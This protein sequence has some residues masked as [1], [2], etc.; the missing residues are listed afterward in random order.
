MNWTYFSVVIFYFGYS[1]TLTAQDWDIYYMDQLRVIATTGLSVRQH[2]RA[3]AKRL[4]VV[5]FGKTVRALS[6]KGYGV[7]TVGYQTFTE[8]GEERPRDCQVPI[9]GQW[10]RVRYGKLQGYV[11][12]AYLVE[13]LNWRERVQDLNQEVV[14]MVPGGDCSVEVRYAPNWYW[15][16]LYQTP[17][18]YA[19]Q[20]VRPTFTNNWQTNTLTIS[21]QNNK[22][23][24]YIIGSRR[25]LALPSAI[26][27]KAKAGEG[28]FWKASLQQNTIPVYAHQLSVKPCSTPCPQGPLLHV[29]DE[30]TDQSLQVLNPPALRLQEPNQLHWCGDLDGDGKDDYI[31]EYASETGAEVLY[32]S[33]FAE[34][35]QHLKAVAAFYWGFCC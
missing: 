2:P 15:Y 20:Q 16:G 17:T 13:S 24:L 22:G 8:M 11:F 18:G 27:N 3:S 14:L 12:G 32:L 30:E 25:A 10:V 29:W 19:A 26:H 21:T 34:K 7:D 9:S 31:I 23:L 1:L 33:S 6:S 5:P 35:G 4:G 28:E